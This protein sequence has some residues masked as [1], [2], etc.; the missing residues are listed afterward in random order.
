M[1]KMV[2]M[3]NQV[4]DASSLRHQVLS[5][6]LANVNT[7]DFQRSDVEF[8]Q[9]YRK[10]KLAVT[11]THDGHLSSRATT[12]S[13]FSIVQDDS[14]ILRNDGNNV[15]PDRE[16]VYLLENQIHYQTMTDMV[17]RNLGLLRSVISEGRR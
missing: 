13:N 15:D 11:K 7:P 6:N 2:N 5:N 17:N 4:L 12:R 3:M 9:V 14:T 10:A 16:M 1:F 8:N